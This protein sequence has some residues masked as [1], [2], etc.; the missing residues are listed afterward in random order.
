VTVSAIVIHPGDSV[1]CLLR[2]HRAG[3]CPVLPSGRA[4]ALAGDTPMGHK[5]ALG[6][7]RTGEPVIKFGAV[8]GHATKDIAPG[9]HVHLH[10]LEG[11][12]R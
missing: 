1:A 11:G 6:A 7:I 8:I 2:D 5:V 4:A 3:E 10:N 12:L 9:D